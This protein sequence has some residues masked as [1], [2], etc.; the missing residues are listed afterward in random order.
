MLADTLEGLRLF[1][2]RFGWFETFFTVLDDEAGVVGEGMV[3]N[4]DRC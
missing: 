1:F 3:Y 4:R 2:D